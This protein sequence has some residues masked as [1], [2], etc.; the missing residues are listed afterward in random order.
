MYEAPPAIQAGL[1]LDLVVDVETVDIVVHGVEAVEPRARAHEPQHSLADEDARGAERRAVEVGHHGRSHLSRLE[2]R[3]PRLAVR[4]AR[5]GEVDPARGVE[6]PARARAARGHGRRCL[7]RKLGDLASK[8]GNLDARV[9]EEAR[10]GARAGQIGQPSREARHHPRA[11][12]LGEPGGRRP[13]H[14]VRERAGAG[15]AHLVARRRRAHRAELD[16][17]GIV[18]HAHGVG[19]RVLVGIVHPP[20]H[21]PLVAVAS[22]EE[23]RADHEAGPESAGE[24]RRSRRLFATTDTEESAMA[25][26]ARM[27]ESVIPQSG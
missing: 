9:H 20:F 18:V 6:I 8:P 10:A 15:L 3:A 23:G 2:Q 4:E 16:A 17:E 5:V 25:S 1:D 12:E 26:P 7:A 22:L 21:H 19:E 11:A 27:G 14:P 24:N 13:V